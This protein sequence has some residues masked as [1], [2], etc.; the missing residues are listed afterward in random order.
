MP[1][2]HLSLGSL[3]NLDLHALLRQVSIRSMPCVYVAE[4]YEEVSSYSILIKCNVCN[5]TRWMALPWMP[6][7]VAPLLHA[8]GCQTR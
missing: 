3:L 6:G 1:V 7:V 2:L 5:F 4:Q 8:T